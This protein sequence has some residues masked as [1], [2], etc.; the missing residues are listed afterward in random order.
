M[1]DKEKFDAVRFLMNDV[2]QKH[3]EATEAIASLDSAVAA[4]RWAFDSYFPDNSD[5]PF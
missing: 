4:M 2:E 3:K 1:T 5:C